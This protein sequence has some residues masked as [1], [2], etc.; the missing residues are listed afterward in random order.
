MIEDKSIGEYT[1]DLRFLGCQKSWKEARKR[2]LRSWLKS[3]VALR[4]RMTSDPTSEAIRGHKLQIIVIL[5]SLKDDHFFILQG[6]HLRPF[7]AATTNPTS[8]AV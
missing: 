7:E 5:P 4:P 6:P 8:K 1:A 3:K 2:F